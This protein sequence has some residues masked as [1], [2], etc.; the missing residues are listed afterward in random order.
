MY[1]MLVIHHALNNDIYKQYIYQSKAHML[2][3][4]QFNIDWNTALRYNTHHS[5]SGPCERDE[6]GAADC[7]LA[8]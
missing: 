7:K 6:A 5:R 3:Q 8:N 2:F 1:T 4:I